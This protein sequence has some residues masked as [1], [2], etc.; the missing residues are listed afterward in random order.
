MSVANKAKL[1]R[2]A[3]EDAA[4]WTPERRAEQA[5]AREADQ[6]KFAARRQIAFDKLVEIVS[7]ETLAAAAVIDSKV[8]DI[9]ETVLGM[10]RHTQ[11][12]VSAIVRIGS[13]VD[14]DEAA[15]VPIFRA[16][17]AKRW[18][19]MAFSFGV[20]QEIDEGMVQDMLTYEAESCI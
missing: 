7:L 12:Q 5:T 16:V 9:I 17:A 2:Y 8:Y 1:A 6:A 10:E 4:Y 20:E 11:K 13:D 3:R 19:V 18:G 15:A 14:F